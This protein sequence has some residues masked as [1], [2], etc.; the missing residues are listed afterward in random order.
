MPLKH[1]RV[2][3][4]LLPGT[5]CDRTSREP[6]GNL[7]Q[8]TLKQDQ[9]LTDL[10]GSAVGTP[11]TKPS[12]QQQPSLPLSD[13]LQPC[14]KEA[15]PLQ[16]DPCSVSPVSKQDAPASSASGGP[17]AT[18][19]QQHTSWHGHAAAE[20]K[21][22]A[23]CKPHRL[24]DG[25]V[26]I[27]SG[28]KVSSNPEAGLSQV[29]GARMR[30]SDSGTDALGKSMY[31]TLLYALPE[32][33]PSGSAQTGQVQTSARRPASLDLPLDHRK[34]ASCTSQ[35]QSSLPHAADY[36]QPPID[37]VSDNCKD[38]GSNSQPGML[39]A[40]VRHPTTSGTLLE[41]KSMSSKSASSMTTSTTTFSS[42]L[43]SSLQSLG[44]SQTLLASVDGKL[45]SRS[46]T[47]KTSSG[48]FGSSILNRPNKCNSS[49]AANS[50]MNGTASKSNSRG[51]STSTRT[52]R[53]DSGTAL[54]QGAKGVVAK[55]DYL[56][57]MDSASKVTPCHTLL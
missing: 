11:Q 24:S 50:A 32:D 57:V 13:P 7:D 34:S 35:M 22:T 46:H 52:A 45:S 20:G 48:S 27:S 23:L 33:S 31:R 37:Y 36:T 5:D 30:Y 4:P 14:Q 17:C 44:S 15:A 42:Q 25:F 49:R 53:R 8:S 41:C 16:V 9:L 28:H 1:A 55:G 2:E 6:V 47:S 38:S 10:N 54:L 43:G 21:F 56:Y 18:W 51:S 19:V 12:P 29:R 3:L 39:D 40:A 26:S